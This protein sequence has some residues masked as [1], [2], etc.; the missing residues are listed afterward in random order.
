MPVIVNSP[1]TLVDGSLGFTFQVTKTDESD[2]AIY[3]AALELE[4]NLPSS[5][6]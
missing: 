1:I 2:D 6:K 5:E 3:N 4:N